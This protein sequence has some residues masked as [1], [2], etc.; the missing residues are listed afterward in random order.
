[1]Q[2]REGGSDSLAV[3]TA[4][5]RQREI[6]QGRPEFDQFDQTIWGLSPLEELLDRARNCWKNTKERPLVHNTNIVAKFC[7]NILL[8]V[9]ALP[10]M[11]YD[12][13][14]IGDIVARPSRGF[15]FR[16]P[17]TKETGCHDLCREG[18]QQGKCPR[19]A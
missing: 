19:C 18:G 7:A 3:L 15:K 2:R 13:R 8:S 16:H 11:T 14:E 10:V 9:G 5:L 1:M 4:V 17:N 12:K 6:L